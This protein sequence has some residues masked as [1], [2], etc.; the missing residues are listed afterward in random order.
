MHVLLS[1]NV[2]GAVLKNDEFSYRSFRWVLRP[3]A[4]PLEA[5]QQQQPVEAKVDAESE[6]A[7]LGPVGRDCDF[8]RLVGDLAPDN[9]DGVE[10]DSFDTAAYD[11]RDKGTAEILAGTEACDRRMELLVGLAGIQDTRYGAA[12]ES[13]ECPDGA[14]L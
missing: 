5:R 3:G 13:P 12:N 1:V 6:R 7:S 4:G 11:G 8:Q 14:R 10:H 2:V 9:Q